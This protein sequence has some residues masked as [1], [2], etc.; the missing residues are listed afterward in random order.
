MLFV[1]FVG[2]SF[3]VCYFVVV[4]LVVCVLFELLNLLALVVRLVV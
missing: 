2:C 4:C 1:M 3:V